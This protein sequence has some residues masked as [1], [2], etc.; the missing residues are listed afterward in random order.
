MARFEIKDDFYLD[1]KP[2]K[3]LSGPF[4]YFRVPVKIGII[5]CINLKG[6]RFQYGLRLMLLL[7]HA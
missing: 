2:F 6:T 1:G 7:E 3:I 5:H 4:Y